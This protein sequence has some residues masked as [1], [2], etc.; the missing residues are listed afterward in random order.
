[1]ITVQVYKTTGKQA[2]MLVRKAIEL[3]SN[4]LQRSVTNKEFCADSG[5]G[6]ATL[7]RW[8]HDKR[9]PGPGGLLKLCRGLNAWGINAVLEFK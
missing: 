7:I 9:K 8:K 4:Q 5:L 1:M 3:R 6:Q 2:Y